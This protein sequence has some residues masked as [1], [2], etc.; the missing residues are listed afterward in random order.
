MADN[1][2]KRIKILIDLEK[3][4]EAQKEVE[5]ILKDDPHS[6]DAR[7]YE[8][9]ISQNIDKIRVCNKKIDKFISDFPEEGFGYYK[10]AC[11]LLGKNRLKKAK[12]MAEKALSINPFNVQY[13]AL[14]SLIYFNMDAFK[15]ADELNKRV[16]EIDSDNYS[17]NYVKSVLDRK[18]KRKNDGKNLLELD[19]CEHSILHEAEEQI[20]QKNFQEA[21]KILRDGIRDFPINKGI[22][23]RFLLY[24]A[25]SIFKYLFFLT[26]FIYI[27]INVYFVMGMFLWAIFRL[28]TDDIMNPFWVVIVLILIIIF[29]INILILKYVYRKKLKAG[30]I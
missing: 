8:I 21:L 7:A 10:K 15:K 19:Y 25:L 28:E 6:F 30:K 14:L 17:A 4:Q 23:E 9:I 22:R 2:I 3:F 12:K 27:K 5:K 24:K 20:L 13:L 1:K 11:V 16:L 18:W 26:K 29:H